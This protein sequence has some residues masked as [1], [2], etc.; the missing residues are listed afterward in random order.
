MEATE[1]YSHFCDDQTNKVF[2]IYNLKDKTSS[3]LEVPY[4]TVYLFDSVQIKNHIYFTGGGLPPADGKGEQFF[5]TALRLIILPGMD[6]KT[7]KLPN[8]KV[9][10]ANHTCVALTQNLIY[11]IGGCNSKAEIPSCEEYNIEKK[12]WREIAYLNEKKM[13]VSVCPVDSKFLYVFGGSSNLKPKESE[14]IEFLDIQDTSKKL[15]TKV[16]LTSGKENW[17]RCFFA[18][19]LQ[20]S[21]DDI[22]L[23]GGLVN[24]KEVSDTMYFNPKKCTITKGPN[25]QKADAFYRMKP[26]KYGNEMLIVGSCEGDLHT[27]SLTEKKWNLIKKSIWNPEIG[28]S[29]KA[30][31]M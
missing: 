4:E 16:A 24:K 30:D 11:V 10:R 20:I 19:C 23:F 28:F 1:E 22:I 25:L 2:V 31:T 21:P 18:G 6:T 3:K 17:K 5:Q 8:M 27:Y 9:S 15:W 7:E 12:T 26:G 13:W 29:V 14:M